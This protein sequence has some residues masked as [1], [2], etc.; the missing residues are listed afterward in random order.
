M[1]DVPVAAPEAEA[2]IALV[3]EKQL[4]LAMLGVPFWRSGGE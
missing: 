4:R 2:E 1:L 3:A